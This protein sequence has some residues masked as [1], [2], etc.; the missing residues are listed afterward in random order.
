MI[1]SFANL[2][3]LLLDLGQRFRNCEMVHLK[4]NKTF[5][6]VGQQEIACRF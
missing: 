5:A 2:A 1:D 4:V 3:V 6:R